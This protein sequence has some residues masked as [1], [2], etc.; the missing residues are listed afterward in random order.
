[1]YKFQILTIF[2][3]LS[4]IGLVQ[5][6]IDVDYFIP[7]EITIN[8]KKIDQK[9]EYCDAS[10]TANCNPAITTP[11]QA[12]TEW[13][14]NKWI[15]K[16]T[17]VM[18]IAVKGQ[19]DNI[20]CTKD[21]SLSNDKTQ[22]TH[23]YFNIINSTQPANYLTTDANGNCIDPTA[24]NKDLFNSYI[25][26]NNFANCTNAGDC[27][28]TTGIIIT[29]LFSQ[30][31]LEP[32]THKSLCNQFASGCS[33]NSSKITCT[34][35]NSCGSNNTA[36]PTNSD[37]YC[38]YNIYNHKISLT[39]DNRTI[40]QCNALNGSLDKEQGP[41]TCTYA[42]FLQPVDYHL[43]D[44]YKTLKIKNK[45]NDYY[46]TIN[47][48]IL[49]NTES[50]RSNKYGLCLP[51]Y[52]GNKASFTWKIKNCTPISGYTLETCSNAN[53]N[54]S[55]SGC[56][57]CSNNYSAPVIEITITDENSPDS[58][59]RIGKKFYARITAQANSNPINY[60][61]NVFHDITND[62]TISSQENIDFHTS[63]YNK[64]KITPNILPVGK[65][66][67]SQEDYQNPNQLDNTIAQ[68]QIISPEQIITPPETEK[69]FAQL[70]HCPAV[71]AEQNPTEY[72][73]AINNNGINGTESASLSCPSPWSGQIT[74][75]CSNINNQY[76]WNVSNHNCASSCGNA[77]L[78]WDYS[79]IAKTSIVT[80]THTESIAAAQITLDQP[81]ITKTINCPYSTNTSKDIVLHCSKDS[82]QWQITQGT[83]C[84]PDC[85]LE[86]HKPILYDGVS[87]NK[88]DWCYKSPNNG[89][90]TVTG[91]IENDDV[92]SVTV[93]LGCS[94]T[95]Y[96]DIDWTGITATY[97]GGDCPV[98]SHHCNAV[99][100]HA[101]DGYSYGCKSTS[102][103]NM[104]QRT[105]SWRVFSSPPAQGPTL[106]HH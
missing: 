28:I 96:Q 33:F 45:F 97:T 69:N 94:L 36:F 24:N 60:I 70:Y 88:G 93:P 55:N 40:N 71:T 39:E 12:N 43:L 105:S 13:G 4:M 74:F 32:G 61:I 85:S 84:K 1:M 99:S 75:Q 47:N 2:I 90:Y 66:Q 29:K 98:G 11:T 92:S 54:F 16:T 37:Y 58:N 34:N 27:S 14:E 48:V 38:A 77:T 103:E 19:K 91:R 9:L 73:V 26:S 30:D 44:G 56:D 78:S 83:D 80:K 104:G 15:I 3:Y 65:L 86:A 79:S 49:S 89:Y 62:Q 64:F 46:E 76:Q 7:K 82:N 41:A 52:T 51:V 57:L 68:T 63:F 25:F 6:N 17:S 102:P 59:I 87:D 67:I 100:G 31:G 20:T 5:A 101:N 95:L 10:N 72:K 35:S 50:M 18:K 23:K 22:E 106:T 53:G 8:G 81:S 42:N 21:F